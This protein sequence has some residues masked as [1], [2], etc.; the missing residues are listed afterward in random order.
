VTGKPDASGYYPLLGQLSAIMGRTDEARSYL[1]RALPDAADDPERLADLAALHA[2]LGQVG[3][4]V[5]L[6]KRAL[7]KGYR[8]PFFPV[9][10]PDFLRIRKSPEFRALF[11][12]AN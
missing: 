4:A 7:E 10:M 3:P 2:Q 1:E 6:L 5:G 9:I 12:L 8:D 11:K